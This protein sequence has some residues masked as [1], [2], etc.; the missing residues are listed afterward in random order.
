MVALEANYNHVH[1][2]LILHVSVVFNE[3]DT[4]S[5][6]LNYVI[7]AIHV[8]IDSIDQLASQ[9][10][11]EI[12]ESLGRVSSFH[13]PIAFTLWQQTNLSLTLSGSDNIFY[14]MYHSQQRHI[15]S[16]CRALQ[17]VA[18]KCTMVA[19]QLQIVA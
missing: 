15:E 18:F 14:C 1:S 8:F 11:G 13:P 16:P 7:D 3:K 5:P 17:V 6:K 12:S 10:L 19:K 2:S 4:Y 9:I